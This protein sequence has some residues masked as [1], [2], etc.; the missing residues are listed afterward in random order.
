MHRIRVGIE[1]AI[2]GVMMS[3]VAWVVERQLMKVLKSGSSSK[4][5]MQK[6][7]RDARR[8][9]TAPGEHQAGV[10]T[11]PDEINVEV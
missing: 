7:E 6:A 9:R 10:T 8:T 5:A 3:V 2:L 4:R 11:S 1:R